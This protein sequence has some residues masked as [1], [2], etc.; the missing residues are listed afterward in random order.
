MLDVEKRK[1]SPKS[2]ERLKQI[3]LN[4][5]LLI[6]S[7]ALVFFSLEVFLRLA[8]EEAEQGYLKTQESLRRESE[9]VFYEF[10]P[11]LGWGNKPLAEGS[12]A[13]PDSKTFVRINS[14]GLRDR[15]YEYAK[16]AGVYRIIVLGDSFAWGYGVGQGKNFADLLEEQLGASVEVIN[17]GVS[18]YGTDQELLFLEREGMKYQPDLVIVA[19]ATNDF[20]LDNKSGRHGYYQKPYFV[21]ENEQ[22]KVENYPVPELKA[23][24]WD[25]L[26]KNW[27]PEEKTA[28]RKGLK[29]FLKHQ[30]KTYPFLSQGFKNMRYSLLRN[31]SRNPTFGRFFNQ[32]RLELSKEDADLEVTREIL[33]RMKEV[34]SSGRARLAVFSVPYKSALEKLPNPYIQDFLDFFESKGIPSFYPYDIFYTKFRAGDKLF[35]NHDD[36]WNEFGHALAAEALRDFLTK[37]KLIPN[38]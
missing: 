38:S 29:G 19:F 2:I 34:A 15:E 11:Y 22:L 12:F 7:I 17:A 4:L 37:K 16:P 9:F 10:D 8:A 27:R 35:L 1:F 36:H 5:F 13:T 31:L 20:T 30:T 14:K 3:T 26:L 28:K 32:I 21:I 24:E 18:G 33:L 6:I 25:E 23:G